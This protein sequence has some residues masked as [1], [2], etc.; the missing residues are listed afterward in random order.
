M[1]TKG[2]VCSCSEYIEL[3]NAVIFSFF[4]AFLVGS[5]VIYEVTNLLLIRLMNSKDITLYVIFIFPYILKIYSVSKNLS[6][7]EVLM[8]HVCHIP[9]FKLWT[10]FQS[11]SFLK[12]GTL[13]LRPCTDFKNMDLL[14]VSDLSIEICHQSLRLSL[15]IIIILIQLLWVRLYGLF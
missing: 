5:H 1:E 4:L 10:A 8:R 14:M 15:I 11:V 9:F 6:I 13:K 3:S 7:S 2:K 12:E